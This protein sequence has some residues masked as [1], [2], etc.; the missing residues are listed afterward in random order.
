MTWVFQ[1]STGDLTRNGHLVA[2]GYAG[3]GPGKFNPNME[4]T[5][6]IGPLPKGKYSI[7]G[8][9]FH[10]PHTGNYSIRLQPDP[11]NNMFGR[12]GFLIHGDSM[13]HPGMAS[14]GCIVLPG[15]IRQLIWNS[16]DKSV[17]VVR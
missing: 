4:G 8:H 15:P 6:N 3:K 14:N 7:I 17:E 13:K 1:Q 9:P 12:A 5:P 16:G 2:K 11:K 10:H